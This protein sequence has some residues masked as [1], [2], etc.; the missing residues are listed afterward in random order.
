[1]LIGGGVALLAAGAASLVT[2]PSAL[3]SLWRRRL[4]EA[5]FEPSSILR[6]GPASNFPVGV[7]TRFLQSNRVCVVRNAA[8]NNEVSVLNEK[9]SYERKN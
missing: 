2:L 8:T 1:L 5:V 3:L 6:I 9:E 7:H 4:P